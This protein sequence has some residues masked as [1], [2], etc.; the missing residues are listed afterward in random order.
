MLR[1]GSYI[2]FMYWVEFHRRLR[3]SNDLT[4]TSLGGLRSNSA[5]LL[6]VRLSKECL[7]ELRQGIAQWGGLGG[8]SISREGAG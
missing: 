7:S 8:L 2:L 6:N 3:Q 5:Q 4:I 1:R